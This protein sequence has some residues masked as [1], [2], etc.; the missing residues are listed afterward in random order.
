MNH[1][2]LSQAQRNNLEENPPNKKSSKK[3]SNFISQ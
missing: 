2:A 3:I 1:S